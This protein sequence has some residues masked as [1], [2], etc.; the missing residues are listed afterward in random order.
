MCIIRTYFHAGKII[1]STGHSL[2]EP[3]HQLIIWMLK[4]KTSQLCFVEAKDTLSSCYREFVETRFLQVCDMEPFWEKAGWVYIFGKLGIRRQLFRNFRNVK[5]LEKA[6]RRKVV[7][8]R[9]QA[10]VEAFK[11]VAIAWGWSA[12]TILM[13]PAGHEILTTLSWKCSATWESI[14]R[15]EWFSSLFTVK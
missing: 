9:D 2:R 10:V 15:V 11:A 3:C 1:D 12:D 8:G 6:W 14:S 13:F 4:G 7:F 5:F